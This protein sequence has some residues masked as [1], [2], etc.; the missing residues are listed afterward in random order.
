MSG[1]VDRL[2]CDWKEGF[3]REVCYD[4][5]KKGFI[6]GFGFIV[7][8]LWVMI[9]VVIKLVLVVLIVW[10]EFKLLSRFF[11]IIFIN[12]SFISSMKFLFFINFKLFNLSIN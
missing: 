11:F 2:W 7:D 12:F 6:L 3:I 4:G 8:H 1:L 5:D 10:D 9:T